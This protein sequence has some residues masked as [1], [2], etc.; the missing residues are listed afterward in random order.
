MFREILLCIQKV[1]IRDIHERFNGYC[2]LC[3][4]P[5]DKVSS[6]AFSI[7]CKP[8]FCCNEGMS[9]GEW[10]VLE[11]TMEVLGIGMAKSQLVDSK[12]RRFGTIFMACGSL[13][14]ICDIF[15]FLNRVYG[16]VTR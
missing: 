14:W 16:I 13:C 8:E 6:R 12:V 4:A 10:A 7:I 11:W 1:P 3:E 2:V 15:S 9:R 5:A